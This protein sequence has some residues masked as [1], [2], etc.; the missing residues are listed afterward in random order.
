MRNS[1]IRFVCSINA[2][3]QSFFCL[4]LAGAKSSYFP[5][6]HIDDDAKVVCFSAT[7]ISSIYSCQHHLPAASQL[8]CIH[9]AKLF[10][11]AICC[12]L[13]SDFPIRNEA[14]KDKKKVFFLLA[15]KRDRNPV[16]FE[17]LWLMCSK[18][19]ASNQPQEPKARHF[20]QKG[21]LLGL[22]STQLSF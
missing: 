11:Y 19:S 7:A 4:H 14:R 22:T 13:F 20:M 16:Q 12:P 8:L 17:L 3:L 5:I 1:F 9:P 18:Q 6:E 21:W 10:V 15:K 2:L